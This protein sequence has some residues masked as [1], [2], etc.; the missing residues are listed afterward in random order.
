MI[1]N[2][3][4]KPIDTLWLLLKQNLQETPA[5]RQWQDSNLPASAQECLIIKN[6]NLDLTFLAQVKS[7]SPIRSA[8]PYN[9]SPPASHSYKL[10]FDGAA[11][12]NPRLA[13]YGGIFRNDVGSAMHIYHGSLG[14][15]TNNA[16]ELEGLWKGI[17]IVEM[18]NFFPLEVEG[19]SKILIE[20]ATQIHSGSSAAKISSS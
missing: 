7:S 13:G 20:A 2:N 11:K 14:K 5:L 15:D 10:N 8:S 19:D 17:C 1:F 12:G 18:E 6:W 3:I 4:S 9:W 16:A